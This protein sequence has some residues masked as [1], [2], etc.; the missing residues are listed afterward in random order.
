MTRSQIGCEHK[1]KR[2]ADV[3]PLYHKNLGNPDVD[4]SA[5]NHAIITRWSMS[6]LRDIKR[7]AW[8][9]VPVTRDQLAEARA[10]LALARG[11]VE[12]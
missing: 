2:K 1:N 6:A 4:W 11:E 8:A 12:A 10:A 3:I 7:G 5:V 9:L